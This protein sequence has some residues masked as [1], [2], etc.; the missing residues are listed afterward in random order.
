LSVSF[1][2]FRFVTVNFSLQKKRARTHGSMAAPV[3]H[4][5]PTPQHAVLDL[6]P[7]TQERLLR[8][9]EISI[10][11]L[12]QFKQPPADSGRSALDQR[13]PF[14]IY[15]GLGGVVLALLPALDILSL[16]RKRSV[17][18]LFPTET[19]ASTTKSVAQFLGDALNAMIAFLK[20]PL[21]ETLRN[22]CNTALM[23]NFA[24][25]L[26]SSGA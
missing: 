19:A 7:A 3:S 4:L 8:A 2:L 23:S 12:V 24:G 25:A 1:V 20:K 13:D 10:C 16:L 6:D 17:A 14:T 11:K 9:L 18:E 5:V 26:V 15:H 22:D 21:N